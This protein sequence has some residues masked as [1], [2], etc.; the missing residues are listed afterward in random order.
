MDIEKYNQDY[1]KYK[2]S[3]TE[4]N[5]Q[6]KLK[7]YG[8]KIGVNT[9][10]YILLLYQMI[11]SNT[12]SIADK[13]IIIAALGYFISPLDIIPDIIITD[14]MMPGMDGLEMIQQ[15]RQSELLCHIPV[16]AITA[17]C[18]EDDKIKGVK[19][20]INHYIYK[21]FDADELN[22]TINNIIQLRHSIQEKFNRNE[23]D[24]IVDTEADISRNDQAFL[25]KV[26][27]IIYSQMSQHNVNPQ[28]IASA[29]C[30]STKQLNRKISAITGQS[31]GKYIIQVRMN[32]AK[33]LLDSNN[34]YTIA[35]VSQLCGY[36]EN[37]NFTRVFKQV[38]GITPSQYNRRP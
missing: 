25:T 15:I 8:K 13:A 12:V 5:L 11:V 22:A 3:Y 9:T 27:D 2:S 37:S 20:G 32:K 4:E 21:P 24:S 36:E 1:G 7:K 16:V 10:Y 28:E 17:K 6:T 29:L 38:Y 30:I 26:I 18:S 14:I 33:N 34:G 35:E 31:L 23:L 19:A